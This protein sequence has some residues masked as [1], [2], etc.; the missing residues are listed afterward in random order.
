MR[1]S[2]WSSDVCSSDLSNISLNEKLKTQSMRDPLTGLY[3]RR[4]M[5]DALERTI[6][7]SARDNTPTSVVMIDLDNFQ[8]PNDALG[9]RSEER[10]GGT[11]CVRTCRSRWSPYH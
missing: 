2:D 1:I 4:Y 8:R 7:S 11:E 5:E 6:D 10:R 9:H 3:N